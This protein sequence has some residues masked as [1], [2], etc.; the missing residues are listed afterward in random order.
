[1]REWTLSRTNQIQRTILRCLILFVQSPEAPTTESGSIGAPSSTAAV[2][3]AKEIE[4]SQSRF[5]ACEWVRYE[6]PFGHSLLGRP[7][8]MNGYGASIVRVKL[9]RA[10]R[11]FDQDR[12]D[13]TTVVCLVHQ[14][15][16]I[17]E[18]EEVIAQGGCRELAVT[19]ERF[20]PYLIAS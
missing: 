12:P 9:Q 18:T 19:D 3:V 13:Q 4:R 5:V 15:G 11:V 7:A 6:H 16:R 14:L 17:H 20:Q 10:V 8:V 1:M 2:T